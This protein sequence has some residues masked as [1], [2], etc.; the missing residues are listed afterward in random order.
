M[1]DS[2]EFWAQRGFSDDQFR[3]LLMR[4]PRVPGLAEERVKGVLGWFENQ[5]VS[6]ETANELVL[7]APR[8]LEQPL[9]KLDLILTTFEN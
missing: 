4:N 9:E 5:G 6:S 7:E 1:S 8:I 2:K 3:A